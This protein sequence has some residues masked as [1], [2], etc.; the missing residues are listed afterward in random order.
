MSRPLS[1]LLAALPFPTAAPAEDPI[2]TGIT[3]DNR[4]V[5]PGSLFVAYKGVTVDAHRFIP[6]AIAR[7]AAAVVVETVPVAAGVPVIHVAN[8][9]E[10]FAR[11]CA[12]WHGH[13]SL[14]M[15]VIGVT[16]TDGKTTTSNLLYSILRA[17]GHKTGM[18]STVNAVIG[19]QTL[20]T[21]L[22]TTTPKADDIQR[23]LAQMRD[24][25]TAF[26][27]LEVTSHGLAQHRVDG[28]D[29]DLAVITNITHEHLDLH[30]TREAYRA[31]KARLFEMARVHVLNVDDEYSFSHLARLDSQRR[32]LYSRE[33]QPSGAYADWWL[34]APRADAAGNIDAH[35]FRPGQ[36]L[37]LP[38][39][40]QLIGEFNVSN[41]LAASTA[42]LAFDIAID[43]IQRGVAAVGGVAGRMQRIDEGQPYLAVVDFAHTPNSLENCL[44]ALRAITPGRLI[45]V[46]GCAGQRDV[47]KRPMMGAAADAL[48][49]IVILTA[50]DPRNESFD[51][52]CDAIAGGMTDG[53]AEVHRVMQRGE[54]LQMACSLARPGDTVVACGKGHEQSMCF[55]ATEYAW[56]DREAMRA[57]IQGRALPLG[58]ALP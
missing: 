8:G 27:V 58:P 39:K 48:A 46:F 11:L 54:A 52:I 20:E 44:T 42:A 26:C 57:A 16:G 47:Q 33:V 7:G 55:G 40:T 41:V 12:A 22:H 24:A 18:I 30:G 4:A 19:D 51:A 29:F 6:D 45:V 25:G 14:A 13:P 21:G 53:R 23:Y 36:R 35:G 9:R 2:I 17:A 15:T 56:D 1:Q 28:V 50:E 34:F 31:A 38:L 43:A 3:D 5:Q 32:L 37:P 10:A 49:D